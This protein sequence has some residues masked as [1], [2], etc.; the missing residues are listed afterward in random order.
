MDWNLEAVQC[1]ADQDI[2]K[3]VRRYVVLRTDPFLP[4]I[5]LCAA[6]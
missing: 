2:P 3:D 1:A 4:L 6:L 5:G